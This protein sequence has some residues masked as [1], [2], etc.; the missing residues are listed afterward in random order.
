MTESDAHRDQGPTVAALATKP[1]RRWARLAVV[2]LAFAL[3]AGAF[4]LGWGLRPPPSQPSAVAYGNLRVFAIN[5]HLANVTPGYVYLA[6]DSYMELFAPEALPC[7]REVVNG[8]VGG[9]KSGEYLR[10]LDMITLQPPPAAVLLSVGLNSL[11]KKSDPGAASAIAAFRESSDALIRRLGEGG[12]KVVV[13]AIPP[14]PEEVAR[15]FDTASLETYSDVLRDIC[16]ARGCT[17]VDVFKEARDGVFW[18][19]KPGLAPDGLHLANLR[20]YYRGAYGELC[21]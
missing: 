14:L 11:L 16:T 3:S 2:L 10:F 8:G 15:K 6:G 1:R 13:V 17:V 5:A 19:A 18:R 21:R 20:R 9:S 12:A 7:G 4:S